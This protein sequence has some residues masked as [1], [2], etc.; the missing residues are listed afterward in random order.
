M[1]NAA[2]YSDILQRGGLWPHSLIGKLFRVGFAT[3]CL[4]V[5]GV[6]MVILL[7]ASAIDQNLVLPGRDVGFLEH[8]AAWGFLILQTAIPVSI[9]RT[10]RKLRHLKLENGEI[11]T[12]HEKE[13]DLIITS[14]KE[15][16]RLNTRGSQLAVSLIYCVGIAALVWNSYQ[17]QF[18][19]II[20][21]YDF[22][23]ST[24]FILSYITTRVYKIYLFLV[25]LP[26]LAMIHTGILVAV[27]RLIRR[28]RIAGQL[29]LFPFHPD[30]LGGFGF[31]ANLISAP[32][33]LTLVVG[34][35]ITAGAFIIHR[36]A[37]I[38]PVIGLIILIVWAA[39]TYIVPILFL[40]RDIVASKREIINKLRSLQQRSYSHTLDADKAD[41]ILIKN[42]KDALEYFDRVCSKVESIS[43]YPHWKRLIGFIG[44]AATPSVL[45]FVFK[46]LGLF[47][48]LG[49]LLARL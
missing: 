13:S 47:P 18:P 26:Y 39:L 19:R 16:L 22:W 4:I 42:E 38:T 7:A 17:N 31:V 1:R 3:Q 6:W 41:F 44:L 34:A 29:R 43:N 49:R 25:L 33:I 45:G 2:R 24:T 21:P 11:S 8:P 9:G 40:R 37:N 12:D 30:G 32:I 36:A 5:T 15:F 10:I 20:V 46:S 35:F 23:D 48:V 28:S 27:L 14:V